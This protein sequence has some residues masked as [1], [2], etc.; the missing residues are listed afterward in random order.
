M[1]YIQALDLVHAGLKPTNYVEIGCRKGISLSR[2]VCPSVAID[3]DFEISYPLEQPTRIFKLP[4]DQFF[5]ERD[6]RQML[7]EPVSFAFID[8]MHLAEY[9]LR[10]FINLERFADANTVIAIDDVLPEQLEWATR[11]RETRAWTGD[12]YKVIPLLRAA[13]PDLKIE[14]FDIEMKGLALISNLNPKDTSLVDGLARHESFLQSPESE[15][16][17]IDEIWSVLAPVKSEALEAY[18]AGLASQRTGQE[19]S[20]G[21][22]ADYLDLLKRSLLNEIYLDDELRLLYLKSCLSGAEDF[23]YAIYHDIRTT[24]ESA[25]RSLQE[26]RMIGRFPERKIHNSGFSHTMM[27]RK[28]LDSL[29]ECLDIIRRNN[30]QGDLIECGVWRGGG[31]ILMA[32]YLRTYGMAGRKIIVAD[33]FEGLPTS[34]YEQDLK[35]NLDKNRFPELAVSEEAV[36][37]NFA[38][39]GLLSDEVVFLKGWFSETLQHAPTTR[40]ALLRLDGD[41]YEST[42]DT[43]TALYDKVVDGGVIIVDDYG[44]IP[45]CRLAVEDFFAARGEAT[46]EVTVVDWTG[47]YWVKNAGVAQPA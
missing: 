41:L 16:A 11:E 8:G 5:A 22:A 45:A 40:L 42:M 19:V 2:A 44:A 46:P 32:G 34:T 35:L 24:R 36:R 31:C 1:N 39:Y 37:D 23:D 29:H 25:Y 43:L 27:G 4:S 10:D 13:R 28:R 47:V 30:V 38:T 17:S 33:S 7:G 14:V 26:S 9:A 6:L 21:L 12:I 18:I 20:T 15:I 3:P